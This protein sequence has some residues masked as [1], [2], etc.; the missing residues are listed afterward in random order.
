ME[1]HVNSTL[2]RDLSQ[3]ISCP[4]LLLRPLLPPPARPVSLCLPPLP[5]SS[6]NRSAFFFA[7]KSLCPPS[8]S[9]YEREHGRVINPTPRISPSF[10]VWLECVGLLHFRQKHSRQL[11]IFI[12]FFLRRDHCCL[13]NVGHSYKLK[14][15]FLSAQLKSYYMVWYWAYNK[16]LTFE[17]WARKVSRRRVI[18]NTCIDF[19]SVI[20][21]KQ[22]NLLKT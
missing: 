11:S 22:Q 20:S 15:K 1:R 7:Q 19:Y 21:T 9:V 3:T 8:I 18:L 5:L 13:K 4:W 10:P 14:S 17:Y 6:N 2:T 12:F 16:A